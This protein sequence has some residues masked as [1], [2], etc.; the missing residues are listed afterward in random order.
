VAALAVIYCDSCERPAT[1]RG[2]KNAREAREAARREENFSY[3]Q[4]D[5]KRL[6][7]CPSCQEEEAGQQVV[8]ILEIID[9]QV[10]S[11]IRETVRMEL[12]K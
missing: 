4:K 9:S 2:L 8:E 1:Y 7:V 10:P 6:D 11:S 3:I 5:G 12:A